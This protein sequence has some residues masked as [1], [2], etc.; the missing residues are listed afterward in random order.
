MST[1]RGWTSCMNLNTGRCRE[2]VPMSIAGGVLIAYLCQK[3]DTN[4]NNPLGRVLIKPYISE[5]ETIQASP[6]NFILKCSK[7]YGTFYTN[8]IKR[9][10][11]WLDI[12]WNDKVHTDSEEYVL[13]DM[14]YQEYDDSTR[15]FNN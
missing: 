1:D 12:N 4:I 14:A 11:E 7:A 6:P 5:D 9:L 3:D 13:T 8:Y 10:Q 2:Y 15:E